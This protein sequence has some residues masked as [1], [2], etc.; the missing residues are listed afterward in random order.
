MEIEGKTFD[1][2]DFKLSDLKGKYVLIDFWGTW[3]G[4]CVGGMP[5]MLKF[6]NKHKE[7]L[8]ILG[9]ASDSEKS[10]T[11]FLEKNTQYNWIHLLDAKRKYV[12]LYAIEGFPTKILLDKEGKI[13]YKETG[14]SKEFYVEVEKL[15]K[16]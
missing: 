14:E 7:N 8:E 6:Y 9:V 12:K 16:K 15:M 5:H 11:A 10:W 4:P 13:I 3:C 2:K 1:K